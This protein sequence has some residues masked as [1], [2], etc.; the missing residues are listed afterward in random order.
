MKILLAIDGSQYSKEALTFLSRFPF[1][2]KPDIHLVHVS[3]LPD[4]FYLA[5]GLPVDLSQLLEKTKQE[6][7]K[8]LDAAVSSCISWANSTTPH[9]LQDSVPGR[10]IVQLA[11]EQ[12]V[13]LIAIGARG[14][15]A[16]DR[17]LLGSVSDSIAKHAPCSVLIIR[18]QLGK[19]ADDELRILISD[20]GSHESTLAIKRFAKLPMVQG[21]KVRIMTVVNTFHAYHIEHTLQEGPALTDLLKVTQERLDKAAGLF[22]SIP[23]TVDTVLKQSAETSNRILEEAEQWKPNLIVMG[24]TGKSGWKR[25]L[26]GSVSTRVMNHSSSSIWIERTPPEAK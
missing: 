21:T 10:A 16:L 13:D 9:L 6:G 12:S 25:A 7:Q 8:I 17:F 24:S 23:G 20:D 5:S 19:R 11:T 26:L 1:P 22:K 2:Q 4:Y 18:P 14:L 15:G 3:P